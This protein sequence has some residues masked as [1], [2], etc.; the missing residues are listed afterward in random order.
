MGKA[1]VVMEENLVKQTIEMWKRH[2]DAAQEVAF[3]ALDYIRIKGFDSSSSAVKA[4][5]WA[6]EEE[7]RTRGA[8][9]L[10]E[11]IKQESNEDLIETIRNLASRKLSTDDDDAIDVTGVDIEDKS[12]QD[13]KGSA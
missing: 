4:I 12:D 1:A 7:R 10:I 3:L 6:Q 8:E 5:E 11:S 13:A 9:A 2:A